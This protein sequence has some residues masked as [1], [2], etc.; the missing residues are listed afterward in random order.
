MATETLFSQAYDAMW[1]ALDGDANLSAFIGSGNAKGK[2]FKFTDYD[3][4][5]LDLKPDDCPALIARPATSGFSLPDNSRQKWPFSVDFTLAHR[6]MDW[7]TIFEFVS[8]FMCALMGSL[9][10]NLGLTYVR[11]W[12]IADAKFEI[13][14]YGEEE[15]RWDAWQV[16]F[17]V[18][19]IIERDARLNSNAGLFDV[20]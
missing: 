20:D 16:T 4:S 14:G 15:D 1:A 8:R 18:T 6:D 17:R 10:N 3:D 13:V 12:S 9:Y 11:L 7:K 5:D 19:V 2:K